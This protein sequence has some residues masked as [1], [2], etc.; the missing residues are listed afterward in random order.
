MP[1]IMKMENGSFKDTLYFIW[2]CLSLNTEGGHFVMA[3]T[4]IAKLFGSKAGIRVISVNFFMTAVCNLTSLIFNELF[5]DSDGL[6]ELGF[7]GLIYIYSVFGVIAFLIL[8]T[9]KEQKVQL[10]K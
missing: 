7:S 8:M 2:V 10:A 9:F 3:P 4:I 5:L 1:S 6:V